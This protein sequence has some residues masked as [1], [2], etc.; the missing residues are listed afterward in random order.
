MKK[1]NLSVPDHLA[2]KIEQRREQLGS[3]S[4]IFQQA[5]AAR[6]RRKEEF[7]ERLKGDEDMEKIIER[8]KREKAGLQTDYRKKGAE[9]GLRWAK[10]ASY[11]ELEYARRFDPTDEEGLYD[12]AIPL[13]DDLLG[14]YFIDAL[15]ADPFTN[16]EWDEDELNEFAKRWLQGWLEAVKDFWAQVEERL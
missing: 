7:E 4:A 11:N 12:P 14:H 10:A 1:F 9:E 15:E 3:L 2:E 5:V 8:L 13:H 16:P 6:I